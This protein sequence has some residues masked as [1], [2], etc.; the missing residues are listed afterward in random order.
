[1]KPWVKPTLGGRAKPRAVTRVNLEQASKVKMRAP[2]RLNDGEGRSGERSKPRR[3]ALRLA[4]VVRT[5]RGEG[6]LRNVGGPLDR[7]GRQVA[8]ANAGEAGE[9]GR[10][11]ERPMVPM[12][13]VMTVEGRGLTSGCF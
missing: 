8:T 4:G 6:L 2:I 7:W 3:A 10:E 11:S 13:L 1:M 12:K 9:P 5:A